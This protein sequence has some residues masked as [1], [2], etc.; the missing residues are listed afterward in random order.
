MN[1]NNKSFYPSDM[2]EFINAVN[3]DAATLGVKQ[4]DLSTCHGQVQNRSSPAN[5]GSSRGTQIWPRSQGGRR[6]LHQIE[7]S[8]QW[9]T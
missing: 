9:K 4:F 5:S 2:F 8:G 1:E 6:N 7:D 3:M